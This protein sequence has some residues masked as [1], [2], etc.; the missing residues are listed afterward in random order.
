MRKRKKYNWTLPAEIRNRLGEVGYGH[1]RA[2]YEAE[3]LLIIL[4]APPAPMGMLTKR[5]VTSDRP[6]Q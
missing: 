5:W 3:H 2:F 1:Q 4:H 6:E